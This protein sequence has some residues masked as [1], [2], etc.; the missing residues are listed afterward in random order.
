MSEVMIVLRR[1]F[2]ERV[3]TRAFVLGT[4]LFPIF[5][6]AVFVLPMLIGM[7][8]GGTRT[9]ALV[10]AA[11]AGIGAEVERALVQGAPGAAADDEKVTYKVERVAG[12]IETVR[13]ELTR[14]VR[15]KELD[16]FLYLPPE[17][18]RGNTAEYRSRDVANMRVLR[19]LQRAVS[20]SV[21]GAR[22]RE[23][24]LD[25]AQVARLVRPVDLQTTRIT[26]DGSDGGDAMAT[27]FLAYVLGFLIYMMILLYGM[28]VLRSVQEEKNNRI[29]EVIVSSMR[30]DRLMMG[31]I[32]G[33][34]SVALLQVTIWG[35]AAAVAAS[36]SA[37][38]AKAL[39][40]PPGALDAVRMAPGTAVAMIAYFLLGFL[41][42]AALYAALGAA[43]NT[44]QEA[45][46][47]QMILPMPLMVSLLFMGRLIGDPLGQA[48]T[49]MGWVPFTAPMSMP[50]RMAATEIPAAQV[51]GSLALLAATVLFVAWLAGKIYRVGILSTG[52]KPTLRELG[53]WLRAA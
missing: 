17:V 25:G 22:L 28:N 2:V 44:E 13:G 1:E 14:R 45:Q 37:T 39:G 3:R 26:R 5:M 4:V 40:L 35:V 8:G 10:D 20:Q 9:V 36:Q 48:A 52:K 53:R 34:A 43:V 7:G 51:A 18:M 12:P 46:Q 41:L 30:A 23:A 21:Q 29:A 38:M 24:G 33:V 6:G 42:Y 50:M 15:D 47:F 16:G 49:V 32:L 19:D 27:F 31:K 11:P